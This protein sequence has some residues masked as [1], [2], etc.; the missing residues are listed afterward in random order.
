M[1]KKLLA[2]KEVPMIY[3]F[4]FSYRKNEREFEHAIENSQ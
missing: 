3:K 1:V 4:F 2:V